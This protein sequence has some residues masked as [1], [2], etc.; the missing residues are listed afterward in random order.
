MD[1]L[2]FI[3]GI[4]VATATPSQPSAPSQPATFAQCERSGGR[5]VVR[6]GTERGWVCR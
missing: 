1:L 5:V 3:V 6:E 4:F 2:S